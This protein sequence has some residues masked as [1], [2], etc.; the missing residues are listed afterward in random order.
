MRILVT[1]AT[2][3]IGRA[4]TRQLVHEGQGFEA[5]AASTQGVPVAGAPGRPATRW[6]DFVRE[7]RESWV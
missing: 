6:A 5:I 2:G 1:G 7:Y 4:L 3:N